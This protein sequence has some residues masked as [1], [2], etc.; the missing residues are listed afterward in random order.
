MVAQVVAGVVRRGDEGDVEGVHEGARAKLRP[1]QTTGDL[2][3]DGVG[4]RPAA[5]TVLRGGAGGVEAEVAQ[6][7]QGLAIAG[8]G[9]LGAQHGR[10]RSPRRVA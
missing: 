7:V 8:V 10:P 1:G 9:V 4:G 2:V 3:I 5:P 6:A